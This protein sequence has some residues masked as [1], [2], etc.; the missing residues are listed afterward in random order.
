[1]QEQPPTRAEFNELKEEVK[2]L[3]QETEPMRL[4][5]RLSIPEANTLQKTF[6]EVARAN[7]EIGL[8]KGAVSKTATQAQ[9]DELRKDMEK[10]LNS[11]AEVQKLILDR[12]PKPPE[13]E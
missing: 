9:V 1:M 3:K 5:R 2:R 11:I 12:L 4:E 8:L 13:S 10:R 6:E 7:T